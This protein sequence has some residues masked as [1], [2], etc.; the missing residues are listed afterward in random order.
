VAD[1][2]EV[3]VVGF[4]QLV[5]GSLELT[6]KIGEGTRD[7]FEREAY[8]LA[9][10]VRTAMP[11]DSGLMAGSVT[12]TKEEGR[13]GVGFPDK[14][15]V[16]YAGWIEF[17]GIREGG[18]NSWAERPYVPQGRYLFPVAMSASPQLV[19]AGTDVA[20]KEIGGFHWKTPKT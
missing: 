3:T 20:N 4:D 2:A 14:G 8:R 9:D 18:R 11:H 1:G 15:E 17:G 10:V 16:P 13:V 5:G 6:D 12:V 19:A 7:E